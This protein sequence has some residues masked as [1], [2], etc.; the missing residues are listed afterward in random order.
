M[1]ADHIIKLATLILQALA[2]IFMFRT[3]LSLR[4]CKVKKKLNTVKVFHDVADGKLDSKVAADMIMAHRENKYS[5][6]EEDGLIANRRYR[7]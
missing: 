1:T 6:D 2:L 5:F 4:K 7:E 3:I